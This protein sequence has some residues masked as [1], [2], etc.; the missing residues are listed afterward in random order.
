[1]RLRGSPPADAWIRRLAPARGVPGLPFPQL[2]VYFISREPLRAP[3][4]RAAFAA[5]QAALAK[6]LPSATLA[7]SLSASTQSR[8]AIA[9]CPAG[10]GRASESAL[11]EVYEYDPVRYQ[12]MVIGLVEPPPETP[13]HWIARRVNPAATLCAVIPAP[14]TLAPGLEVLPAP[15]GYL[16]DPNTLLAW[17]KILKGR[18]VAAVEG[19]GLVATGAGA[20]QLAASLVRALARPPQR[21]KPRPASAKKRK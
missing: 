4:P 21:K 8:F 19:T 10:L 13:I 1:M 15:R 18:E 20:A 5:V 3:A 14:P 6:A 12:A 7:G 16:G 17:G 11:C 2:G 9:A